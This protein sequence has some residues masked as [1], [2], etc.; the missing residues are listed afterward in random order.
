MK[1]SGY[2]TTRNSIE[3]NYP[4][5]ECILSMLDFCD[6]VVVADSSDHDDGTLEAL[7]ELMDQH[8][9][10]EVV[11]VDVDYSVPNYGVWDGKMKAIAR[12]NCTGDYLWQMDCDEVVHEGM[13]QK[14]EFIIENTMQKSDKVDLMALPVVEFWGSI[15]KVRV[16]VN[17]WKWRLSRNDPNITHGIPFHLRKWENELLYAQHGTDGC[18][19][20][21]KDS[22]EVVPCGHFMTQ[23]V[24][25]LRRTAVNGDKV[26]LDTYQSWF[27]QAVAELPTVYHYSWWSVSEKIKKF[28]HTWNKQWLSLYNEERPEGW[29]PFFDQPLETVTPQQ[30][31]MYSHIVENYT[32]GHI[33]HSKWGYTRTPHV[34]IDQKMPEFIKP[35][36]K[37]VT[38]DANDPYITRAQ[39]EHGIFT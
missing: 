20:I 18:D 19:Y 14:L 31:T 22:G 32:G 30:I 2:T 36:V 15:G 21:F 26:A 8:D 11:H 7:E 6:E 34:V 25:L 28:Q 12:D 1:I 24:E 9:K 3:M 38:P 10:L 33:F 39:A 35:W 5:R 13:R 27:N 4:F 23:D 16:D 17:P 37:K 29:N